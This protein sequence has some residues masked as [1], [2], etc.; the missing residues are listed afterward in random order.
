M[1]QHDETLYTLSSY[2]MTDVLSHLDTPDLSGLLQTVEDTTTEIQTYATYL[3]SIQAP[4]YYLLQR[5]Y[6][7]SLNLW[8]N[9]YTQALSLDVV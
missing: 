2:D 9:P 3:S 6:L 5:I 8:K 1:A 7:P 4:Y